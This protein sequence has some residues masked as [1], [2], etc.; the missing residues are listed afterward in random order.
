MI[1]Y[2]F[3]NGKFS[4]Y[5]EASVPLHDRSIFFGDGVYDVI[6]GYNGSLFQLRE[7]LDRFFVNANAV[8]IP[9]NFD[10]DYIENIISELISKSK[11]EGRF[12]VY[13][14]LS[15]SS[16]RRSHVYDNTNDS[17]LLIT[18]CA[19]ADSGKNEIALVSCED[20]RYKM[21]NI[22]TINLLP[23]VMAANYA[24]SH[25]AD[26]AVFVRNGIV[27]E[28]SHSNL[29]ILKN[30]VLFTHPADKYILNGIMRQNFIKLAEDIRIPTAEKEFTLDSLKNAD[31]VF[32]T[33]T[34]AFAKR[35]VSLDGVSLPLRQQNVAKRLTSMLKKRF[36]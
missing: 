13:I 33:S 11:P 16:L 5:D 6:L 36:F 20:I 1:D 28:C 32:I 15:R 9:V 18:V 27:T 10:K 21:C 7:H 8:S 25:E 14:Q 19:S 35:C 34:T 30:G 29:F 26:E 12:T 22:K 23:S 4:T 24:N 3:Y 31:E 17:K 2:A